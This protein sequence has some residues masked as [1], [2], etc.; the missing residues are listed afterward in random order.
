MAFKIPIGAGEIQLN[1]F[2]EMQ[3]IFKILPYVNALARVWQD[4]VC[5]YAQH[6]SR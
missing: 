3:L 1:N 6:P 5:A 4:N 2:N